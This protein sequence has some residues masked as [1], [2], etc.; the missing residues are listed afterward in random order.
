VNIERGKSEQFHILGAAAHHLVVHWEF[1]R[2]RQ[3]PSLTYYE[4]GKAERFRVL[5][6]AARRFKKAC[7]KLL[8]VFFFL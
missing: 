4:R 1:H 3:L 2:P 7:A 5:T 6:A 8:S